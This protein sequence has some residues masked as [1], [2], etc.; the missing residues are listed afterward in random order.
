VV[1]ANDKLEDLKQRILMFRDERDW[2]QFHDPKNLAEAIAIE[3]GELLEQFLWKTTEQAR[4]LPTEQVIRVRE[5]VAD[6][7]IFLLY[8]CHETRIDILEAVSSKLESNRAKYPASKARGR[9]DKYS[10]L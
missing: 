2:E 5:E 1:R 9:S 10:E 6:I 3:A 8:F 7:L 4:D